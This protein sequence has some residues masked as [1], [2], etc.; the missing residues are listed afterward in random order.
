MFIRKSDELF[1]SSIIRHFMTL[2]YFLRNKRITD[3]RF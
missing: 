3:F 2:T 1:F